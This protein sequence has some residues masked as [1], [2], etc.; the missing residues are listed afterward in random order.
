MNVIGLFVILFV[1]VLMFTFIFLYQLWSPVI[2]H[3]TPTMSDWI[4]STNGTDPSIATQKANAQ[5]SLQWN[6]NVWTYWPYVLLLFLF[7]WVL[8]ASQKKEPMYNYGGN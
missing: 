7:M 6:R 2:A 8:I 3:V 4:N 5:T 1:T